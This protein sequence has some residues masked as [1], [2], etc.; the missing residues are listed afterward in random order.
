MEGEFEA[1]GERLEG[2]P[3]GV[4]VGDGFE[5]GDNACSEFAAA[6]YFLDAEA[7]GFAEVLEASGG[8]GK[9]IAFGAGLFLRGGELALEIGDAALEGRIRH[10][11]G[12]WEM[13]DGEWGVVRGER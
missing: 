11:D 13:G 9:G 2:F 5:A 6:S 4:E 10:G 12:R 3:G 7:G 1:F 8:A